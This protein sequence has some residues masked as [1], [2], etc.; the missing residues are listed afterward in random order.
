MRSREFLFEYDRDKTI[1]QMGTAI[2]NTAKLDNPRIKDEE[3]SPEQVYAL[4][5]NVLGTIERADPTPN[6]K[7]VLWI[8]RQ[9]VKNGLKL[10][11]INEFLRNDIQAFHELPKQRKQQLGIETDLNK[12]TWRDLREIATKLKKTTDLEEPVD[13]KLDYEHIEDMKVLYVGDMG[14]LI[15]PRTTEAS[16]EIGSGTRWCTAATQSDN[17]FSYYAE[18]GPLYVWIPSRKMPEKK[19]SNKFQFHFPSLQFMDENDTEIYS[20][21]IRYFRTE[22]PI[23]KKVFAKGE[24]TIKQNPQDALEYAEKVIGGRWPEAENVFKQDPDYALSYAVDVIGGRWPEAENVFKQSPTYAVYYAMLVIN[25]RWTE[26]EEVIKK[27]PFMA[28][29]YAKEVIGSRWPEAEKVIKKDPAHAYTYARKVIG[30]RWPDAENV[31]KA[32]PSLAVRYA[33][34]VIDGRWTEA[35]KSIKK[36][37]L[38]ARR[39]AITVIDGRWPEA[40]ETIKQDSSAW[41]MYKRYFDIDDEVQEDVASAPSEEYDELTQKNFGDKSPE[42]VD[43]AKQSKQALQ[44]FYPNGELKTMK[45][46]TGNFVTQWYETPEEIFLIGIN[47]KSRRLLKNDIEDVKT[48]INMLISAMQGGKTLITSPH[49]KSMQMLN[50]VQKIAE[51]RGLNFSMDV[52]DGVSFGDDDPELEFFQVQAT[53][54]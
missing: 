21:L 8:V 9:F 10:E 16:C 1:E 17:M 52:S 26:G 32:D 39:Y 28:Y 6:K 13:A 29:R 20:E 24:E 51:K 19:Q 23:L 53:I 38:A 2:A 45:S 25:G 15:I 7:Y 31:I 50:N 12:Y 42:V 44:A 43:L 5:Q 49:K 54:N 14:Q 40:E 30:G 47:T 36:D 11:D 22:H 4:S 18:D 34:H 41:R 35:E 48:F 3:L 37:P 33:E 27:D 46:G